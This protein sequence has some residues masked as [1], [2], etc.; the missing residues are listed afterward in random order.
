MWTYAHSLDPALP[1]YGHIPAKKAG[2]DGAKEVN[3]KAAET[4]GKAEV[5]KE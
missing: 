3:D 2:D 5:A 1:P 4:A